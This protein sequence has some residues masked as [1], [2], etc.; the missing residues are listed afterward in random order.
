[1]T[2]SDRVSLQDFHVMYKVWTGRTANHVI[3][4]CK[5]PHGHLRKAKAHIA[6]ELAICLNIQ[7]QEWQ[8]ASQNGYAAILKLQDCLA[9][10]NKQETPEQPP[11][12]AK[13]V[14]Q[15]DYCCC[16][17]QSTTQVALES[18]TAQFSAKRNL[19]TTWKTP[20]R[21]FSL[22]YIKLW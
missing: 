11:I 4:A 20:M 15:V 9:V 14:R 1:M 16:V 5:T 7:V 12:R 8:A 22:V 10:L 17:H 13:L 6:N 19:A 18:C 3:N 2:E 21:A